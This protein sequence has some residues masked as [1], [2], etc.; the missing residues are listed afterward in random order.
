MNIRFLR[1]EFRKQI[2]LQGKNQEFVAKAVGKSQAAVSNFL[3]GGHDVSCDA[4]I[5]M[6]YLLGFKIV[7][8]QRKD[9][10]NSN[11]PNASPKNRANH[12][13]HTGSDP[14]A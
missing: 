2:K 13:Q 7:K 1:N 3:N 9:S 11:L 6:L 14:Q 8:R 5:K 4:F 10:H 12:G